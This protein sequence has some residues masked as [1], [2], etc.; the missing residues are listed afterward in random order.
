MSNLDYDE[1]Q[2]ENQKRLDYI[3]TFLLDEPHLFE[4]NYKN[5]KHSAINLLRIINNKESLN[6]IDDI[7]NHSYD[8]KKFLV[9]NFIN[10][11]YLNINPNKRKRENTNFNINDYGDFYLEVKK[12]KNEKFRFIENQYINLRLC[13]NNNFN[14]DNSKYILK[15]I[16]VFSKK[17]FESKLYLTEKSN[18]NF[19]I[20]LKKELEILDFDKYNIAEPNEKIYVLSK[21][22]INELLIS[23]NLNYL[24]YIFNIL[25]N[26]NIETFVSSFIITNDKCTTKKLSKL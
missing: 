2:K 4:Y 6:N 10:N 5:K 20:E 26:K 15:I 13:N 11:C 19:N 9:N 1:Q 18:S 22:L 23:K 25:K 3:M 12:I 8:K 14:Y 24:R 7:I 17:I 16:E 21:N